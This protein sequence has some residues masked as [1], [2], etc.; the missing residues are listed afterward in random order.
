MGTCPGPIPNPNLKLFVRFWKLEIISPVH[1]IFF[2]FQIDWNIWSWWQFSFRFWNEWCIIE[3]KPVSTI[4]FHSNWKE[5]EGYFL[6]LLTIPIPVNL[7]QETKKH[8]GS[9]FWLYLPKIWYIRYLKLR[10]GNI[11]HIRHLRIRSWQNCSSKRSGLPKL[12]IYM[13]IYVYVYA[14]I[15]VY[16][17]HPS[18]FNCSKL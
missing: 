14:C 18:S 10:F 4:I 13:Y 3:R 1:I 5:T 7:N 16:A 12:C 9:R 8:F 6:F 15:I 17:P 2:F 11:G